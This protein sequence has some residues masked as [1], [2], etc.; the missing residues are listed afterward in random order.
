[1][2][3]RAERRAAARAPQPR[4]GGP[5]GGRIAFLPAVL[6]AAAVLAGF[7]F[8]SSGAYIVIRFVVAILT[9]IVAVFAAQGRPR[10]WVLPLG[11]V[12]VLFNPVVPIEITGAVWTG[13]QIGAIAVLLAAGF[14]VRRLD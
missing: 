2:S 6:A 5:A 3:N 7:G 1:M 4:R 8:A 11:A 13:V 12:V 9:L 10:W 14:T